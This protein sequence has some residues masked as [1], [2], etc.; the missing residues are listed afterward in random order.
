MKSIF[1]VLIIALGFTFAEAQNE[2]APIL[3]KEVAYKDWTYKNL[4]TGDD[5]N[6][7][8]FA[9]G[10]KLVMVV[11]YAPWC[12]NWKH[13]A[14]LVQRLYEKYKSSG[15]DVIAVGEYDTVDAM[16][17]NLDSLKIAFQSVA[18]SESRAD[19]QKTLHYQY[20]TA[21]GDTRKWGSPWYIFLEPANIEKQ[22]DVLA[23]KA[24]L[25]NGEL[26]EAEAERFIQSKL[27][28]P[29]APAIALAG[30]KPVEACESESKSAASLKP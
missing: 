2:Q 28:L 22:G 9:D 7:R 24:S 13:D 23:K 29:Q 18:E 3:E 20:R 30:A 15:F 1:A 16:K 5:I 21:V 8:K 19:R 4:K 27:G 10:K 25:V 12:P 11:Y 14:P 6:L 26:I 17:A